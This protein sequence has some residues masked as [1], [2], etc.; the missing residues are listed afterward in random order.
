[1]IILFGTGSRASQSSFYFFPNC[2]FLLSTLVC[3]R[4]VFL[5][6]STFVAVRLSVD[7]L[8]LLVLRFWHRERG[9]TFSKYFATFRS[10]LNVI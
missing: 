2:Y 10:I 6:T 1:M 8:V 3:S 9:A 7:A 5:S 4:R